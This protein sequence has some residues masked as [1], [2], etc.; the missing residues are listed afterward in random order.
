[1]N[2]S[3]SLAIKPTLVDKVLP[4]SLTTDIVLVVAGAAL[5]AVAAQAQIPAQPVPFTF[6][7]LAVLLTGAA[8]GSTRGALSMALYALAGLA[9]PV[10]SGAAHGSAVLF[11]ATGGYIFGF[12]AAGFVVGFLAERKWSS[13]VLKMFVAYAVGSLVIYGFGVPVLAAVAFKGDMGLGIK[14]GLVPFLIWDAVKAAVAAGLLPSAW[15]LVRKVKG[16]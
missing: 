6:Q 15:A 9:L 1:V 11:G 8:L 10:Y 2:V 16:N 4:K 12:I 3:L 13:N 7:T 5:T 14:Y